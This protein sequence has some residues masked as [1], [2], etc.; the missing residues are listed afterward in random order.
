MGSRYRITNAS[1]Y[2]W[3][4]VAVRENIKELRK[5]RKAYEVKIEQK[6]REFELRH[7]ILIEESK[8]K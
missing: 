4:S 1:D 7:K 3:D 5:R 2:I 8:A 6:K